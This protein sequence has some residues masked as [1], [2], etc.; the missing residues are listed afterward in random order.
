MWQSLRYSNL[1]LRLGLA[2]VFLWL[3]I[4]KF[5]HPSYW[6]A[7]WIPSWLVTAASSVALSG[8]GV[9]Y[10]FGAFEVLVGIAI[11][12]NLFVS[13]F[14]ILGAV[15]LAAI[16]FFAGFGEIAVR[17]MGLVAALL[18]LAFWP[19]SRVPRTFL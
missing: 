1:L 9:A 6:L 13:T 8:Y 12:A 2:F 10:L 14:A 16:P 4:D 17:D 3:G 15:F 19:R 18:A 7:V 11:L 5:I